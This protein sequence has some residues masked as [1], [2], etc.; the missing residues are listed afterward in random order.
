MSEATIG[1]AKRAEEAGLG[2]YIRSG[3][4]SVR[5]ADMIVSAGLETAVAAGTITPQDAV[6]AAKAD[7]AKPPKSKTK[8]KA[9]PSKAA[10]RVAE[11]EG[12]CDALSEDLENA[13]AEVES[14]EGIRDD[15]QS[16]L[17][18]ARGQLR[19]SELEHSPLPEDRQEILDG[20]R[21][22]IEARDE[23]IRVLESSVQDWQTRYNDELRISRGLKA[24]LKELEGEAE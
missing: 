9:K 15:L 13:H 5:G 22:K 6:K 18:Q 21:E 10:A 11:L 24:R 17:A 8:T 7:L 2:E 19:E 12:Q 4:I 3:A 1:R 23:R 20:Y 16:N 14:L